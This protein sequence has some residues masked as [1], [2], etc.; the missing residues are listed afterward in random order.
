ME[1]FKIQALYVAWLRLLVTNKTHNGSAGEDQR[2]QRLNDDPGKSS[3]YHVL[4]LISYTGKCVS[5][6]KE[7]I[8]SRTS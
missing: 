4:F 3:S 2:E 1:K 7:A 6:A 8:I 5:F